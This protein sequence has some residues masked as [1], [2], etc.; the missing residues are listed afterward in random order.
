MDDN[1]KVFGLHQAH[2]THALTYTNEGKVPVSDVASSL[3]ANEQLIRLAV[4]LL[5]ELY[6]GLEIK[7]VEVHFK[8]ASHDSPLKEIFGVS[9]FGVFQEDLEHDIPQIIE[10]LTGK[11][12]PDSYD[13]L[14]SIMVFLILY[15]GADYLYS[16]FKGGKSLAISDGLTNTI[17]VAG[18]YINL[19]P[20]IIRQATQDVFKGQRLQVLAKSVKGAVMPAK[21]DK[22]AQITTDA[23][24]IFTSQSVNDFP[25]D[26]DFEYEDDYEKTKP[27]QNVKISLRATDIDKNNAGWA[28]TIVKISDTRL[29]MEIYP[30]IDLKKLHGKKS[31]VGNIILVSRKQPN[32]HYKPVAFHLVEIHEPKKRKKTSKNLPNL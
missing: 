13:S 19:P 24:V 2:F 25:G 1:S 6:P 12:V 7:N 21:S 4:P 3:L 26:I 29:K 20:E 8:N 18:D 15:F 23:G 27:Y 17:N 22:N 10:H 9:L 14:I 31:I 28:G 5:E 32:G 16:R 11:K 30:T